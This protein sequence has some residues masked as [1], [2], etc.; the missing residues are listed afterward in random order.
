[1]ANIGRLIQSLLAQERTG[2]AKIEREQERYARIVIP[3]DKAE[4][5][6]T[7]I[8]VHIK[9]DYIGRIKY[10]GSATGC[11]FKLNNKHSGRIYAGEFR[12]TY[13]EYDRIYL[14]NPS[15]QN[16]KQLVLTVGGAFSSE[17]EPSSGGKTGLQDT[18]GTDVDPAVKDEYDAGLL[19][20]TNSLDIMDDWDESNRCKVNLP[21]ATETKLDG[22]IWTGTP[23]QKS[24]TTSNSQGVFEAST[25]KLRSVVI[26]NTHG[27]YDALIGLTTPVFTVAAG[28]SLA[29]DNVDMHLL[30]VKTKSGTNHATLELI[31][32]EEA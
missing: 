28:E 29:L 32:T 1:M 16:G 21:A 31:G 8:E 22:L 2:K 7:D 19:L 9:G 23:Y 20:A 4:Y 10:D 17:I 6:G 13:S 24:M 27:S 14:S 25:K 30:Y 26:H 5:V 15:S 12:R 18:S 3:L 11:Y